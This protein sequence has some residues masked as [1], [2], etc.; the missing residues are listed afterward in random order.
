MFKGYTTS[1]ADMAFDFLTHCN[2][3]HHTAPHCT[4]L[5]HTAPHCTTLQHTATHCNVWFSRFAR[6]YSIFFTY[7]RMY[8]KIWQTPYHLAISRKSKVDSQKSALEV[9]HIAN[10]VAW[11]FLRNANWS[12]RWLLRNRLAGSFDSTNPTLILK[13][14]RCRYFSV[15][16]VGT[17][18]L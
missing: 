10:C 7:V 13:S 4:A 2:T 15:S 11:R 5:H 3:L 1:Q 14:Q 16:A 18:E 12:A 6:R 17:F 8:T 9:F